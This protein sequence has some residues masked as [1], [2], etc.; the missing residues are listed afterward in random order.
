MDVVDAGDSKAWKTPPFQAT[1]IDGK[2]FGRGSTNMK[3][4]LA[5]IVIA[6]IEIEQEGTLVDGQIKLL[7][8][9]SEE[10]EIEEVGAAQL[11]KLGYADDLNGLIIS[12]PSVRQIIYAH[13]GLMNY[14]VVSYGKKAH[15][16]M[17]KPGINVIDNLLLF[18][19]KWDNM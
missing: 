10:I 7:A 13:K 19:L 12:K 16:S 3:S 8:T 11:T 15:N 17:L 14:T 2:L 1:E 6:M 5:A 18:T 4:G 9:V